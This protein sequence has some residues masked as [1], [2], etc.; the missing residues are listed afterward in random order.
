MSRVGKQAIIL[1]K[2]V[3][4]VIGDTLITAKGPKGELSAPLVS[5]IG[6]DLKDKRLTVTC[7]N[8]NDRRQKSAFGMVRALIANA[9]T[10]V[11]TGFKREL[12]L[13]GVGYRAQLKGQ[14]LSLSL[15]FS[16]PIEYLVPKEIKIVVEK[17]NIILE[18]A[19][20]QL[21]GQVASE[22][23]AFRPPE[24]YKG[25]GVRYLNERVIMKEGKKK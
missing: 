22:I 24:P 16:H 25:K 5:G 2:A 20:K 3:S 12:E 1:P 6:V 4:I 15:G 11:T 13:R 10:G 14:T 23:R 8:L 17:S 21:L 18:G 7:D 19:D 9:V